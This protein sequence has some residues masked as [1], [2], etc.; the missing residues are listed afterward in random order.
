MAAQGAVL[1]WG[2]KSQ[3]RIIS[4][5]LRRQGFVNQILFDHSLLVPDF[6]TQA[7][8][9][10][11]PE[12]LRRL[13]PE[14]S[15]AV[16]C[17]GGNYGAQRTTLSLGLRDRFGLAPRNVISPHAIID[18]EAELAEGVQIL[19]G[20]CVGLAA[21]IGAFS[22]IN[23]NASIDHE[24]TI[25][26]GVHVMGGAALA[27]KV[28]VG[29]HATIGTNATIL[30]LVTIG[31]G[32]QVGAGALVRASV[33]TNQVVVGVPAKHLRTQKPIIDLSILDAI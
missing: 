30:P 31:E 24:C 2:A 27:G 12:E 32:A 15:S 20:A 29:N 13:L 10:N 9:V 22:I 8:F 21:K 26:E 3:A 23:S 16:V 18:P 4:S 25:G 17:V 33:A 11:R 1:L 5:L 6:L 7:R 14:C 28:I 19:M